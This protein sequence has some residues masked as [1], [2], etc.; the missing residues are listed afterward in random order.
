MEE[1]ARTFLASASTFCHW[2]Q[3]CLGDNW[4]AVPST[5][6]VCRTG[7]DC[8]GVGLVTLP[9]QTCKQTSEESGQCVAVFLS[10]I[11]TPWNILRSVYFLSSLIWYMTPLEPVFCLPLCLWWK[12]SLRMLRKITVTIAMNIR[13]QMIIHPNKRNVSFILVRNDDFTPYMYLLTKTL[14]FVERNQG[15]KEIPGPSS[16]RTSFKHLVNWSQSTKHL[17]HFSSLFWSFNNNEKNLCKVSFLKTSFFL[18]YCTC[19]HT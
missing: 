3:R 13:F 7:L 19:F 2:S 12:R 11:R 8:G 15:E 14:M 10:W 5:R 1:A 16:L 6:T 17:K 18:V 9:K 4:H